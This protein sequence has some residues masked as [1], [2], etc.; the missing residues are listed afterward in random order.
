ML[1]ARRDPAPL[2][3]CRD[4]LSPR[5][6]ERNQNPRALLFWNEV[7]SSKC[8]ARTIRKQNFAP[9]PRSSRDVRRARI[10]FAASP[11]PVAANTEDQLQVSDNEQLA[12]QPPHANESALNFPLILPWWAS[13]DSP[14]LYGNASSY[15]LSLR[16]RPLRIGPSFAISKVSTRT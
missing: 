3:T 7:T 2:P 5:T 8:Q 4:T 10:A 6:R 12:R 9:L 13:L 15:P 16:L 11:M 1:Q 14:C